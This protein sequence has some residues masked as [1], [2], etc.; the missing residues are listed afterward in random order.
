MLTGYPPFQSKT[1]EEIYK[2]VRNLTYVW[3]KD[4]ES[5]NYIPA[6]AQS[7]VSSCL[8]LA[9]EER[10]DPDDIVEHAFFDMYEG[11]IP[12]QLDPSCCH[13]KP[14]WLKNA[15]PRG[16]Q[17]LHGYGLDCDDRLAEYAANIDD[18]SQRYRACKTAFYTMCGVGKKPDGNSRKAAGKNCS[19]SAYAEC[20]TED[21][22]GLQPVMPLPV[23]IVYKYPHDTVGDWS[24]PDSKI[25]E[26]KD[27]SVSDT[28]ILSG[29]F[30]VS[31]QSN[32]A[33][34]SRTQ[35]ALAAAQQRRKEPQSHAAALRQQSM[36][37]TAARKATEMHGAPHPASQQGIQQPTAELAPRPA[38]TTRGF[39]ERPIR[40][41]REVAASNTGSLRDT[42]K[43][44]AREQFNSPNEAGV[45]K[46]GKTR[47]QSRKLDAGDQKQ[48][49]KQ[50]TIRRPLSS[51]SEERP[52]KV[53]QSASQPTRK[54][55]ARGLPGEAERGDENI[56]KRDR[57]G[58]EVSQ[59]KW[60]HDG[61]QPPRLNRTGSKKTS[62]SE[63]TSSLGLHGL[64]HPEDSCE[65]LPR[66]SINDVNTDLRHMLSSL[67]PHTSHRR[68]AGPYRS[69]HTYVMKWVDYSHRYGVGYVL[70]DGSVGCL[71][72][73]ENGQSAS[74]VVVRDGESHLRRK[75]DSQHSPAGE[76]RTY[77]EAKQL[78]PRS[79]KPVEF[80][81]NCDEDS[82][83]YRGG[84]RRALI[85]PSVF[86][87]KSPQS[88]AS[89]KGTKGSETESTKVNA[90]KIKRLKLVDQFGKYMIGS[91]GRHGDE[92]T[93]ECEGQYIKF[94]QR[95]GNVGIWGFG[96]GAFQVS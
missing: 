81:E 8:S 30:T 25:A 32:A 73:A 77:S 35:A 16:D 65:L 69:R 59:A 74:S 31:I 33:T 39:G 85:S 23:D 58:D 94:Y 6:E 75:S 87:F 64:F 50:S 36:P 37:G 47:A 43:H 1:Q 80:Y 13:T 52:P 67:I 57:S 79:G 10:P 11:C 14:T 68:R 28:S 82:F 41:R 54:I 15:E 20:V 9:E 12:K 42:G 72:N 63:G 3:P 86:E 44:F 26:R 62:R 91:L 71:F 60:R 51:L 84:I 56:P 4:S 95:L 22:R 93:R 92:N 48:E 17:M 45:L 53:P 66:T 21:E 29:T 27:D 90:G 19:K 88:S 38:V 5:S 78:V 70:D 49:V 2:K 89:S 34:V 40:T 96:D 46:T 83:E 61:E 55:E 7:L 24:L 18:P 76:G